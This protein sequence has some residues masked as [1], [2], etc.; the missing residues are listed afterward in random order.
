M[1]E[2]PCLIARPGAMPAM[3]RAGADPGAG[4]A[5]RMPAPCREPGS[6][7]RGGSYAGIVTAVR[8]AVERKA[9]CGS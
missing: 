2:D 1:P 4:A 8:K 6:L 7:W 3:P 5:G 9:A